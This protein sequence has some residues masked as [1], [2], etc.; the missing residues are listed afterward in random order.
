MKQ[1]NKI[2]IKN[3]TVGNID[4][5]QKANEGQS[6]FSKLITNKFFWIALIIAFVAFGFIKI[7]QLKL[8]TKIFN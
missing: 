4:S 7:D 6:G 2:E 1:E 3:S 8:I 5:S